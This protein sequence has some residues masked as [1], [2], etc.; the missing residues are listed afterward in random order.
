MAGRYPPIEP[1]AG[2][3]LDV[4]DGHRLHWDVCGNGAGRPALVLH[5]GPGSGC[6][7]GHRRYFDPEVY[8]IVLFDQRG[9]GRSTP[10]ASRPDIDLSTNTTPHLLT[11]IETLRVHLGIQRWLVLGGSWGRRWPWPMPRRIRNA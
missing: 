2:G 1:H 5:G 9:A 3:M 8:R 6:G 4:G 10:R 7:P 11:D